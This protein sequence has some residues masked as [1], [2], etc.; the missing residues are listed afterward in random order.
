MKKRN[1]E[2]KQTKKINKILTHKSHLLWNF[3]KRKKKVVLH[4]T[5]PSWNRRT[6]VY[7]Y[8]RAGS[9]ALNLP[10]HSVAC[11]SVTN[12]GQDFVSLD[13]SFPSLWESHPGPPPPHTTPKSD[14]I[15]RHVP[16]KR[17]RISLGGELGLLASHCYRH[18]H[19]RLIRC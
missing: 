10:L 7:I 13:I 19:P 2:E 11:V 4:T 9:W 18:T 14:T 1:K 6:T 17:R 5:T 8:V 15:Q 12:S 16:N 3:S